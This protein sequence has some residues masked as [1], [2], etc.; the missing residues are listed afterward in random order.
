MIITPKSIVFTA[1]G[2]TAV[3]IAISTMGNLIVWKPEFKRETRKIH[4]MVSEKDIQMREE[5][6]CWWEFTEYQTSVQLCMQKFARERAIRV[7]ER[8]I[9]GD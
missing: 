3:I 9:N 6:I 4:Q 1:A 7:Y 8:T 5:A 2:I